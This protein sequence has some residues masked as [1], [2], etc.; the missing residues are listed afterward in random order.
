MASHQPV[1]RFV[2]HLQAEWYG[3]KG[4]GRGQGLRRTVFSPLRRNIPVYSVHNTNVFI[5]C[6]DDHVGKLSSSSTSLGLTEFTRRMAHRQYAQEVTTSLVLEQLLTSIPRKSSGLMYHSLL[7]PDPRS[8]LCIHLLQ[9]SKFLVSFSIR[10]TEWRARCLPHG[11]TAARHKADRRMQLGLAILS[12][13]SGCRLIYVVNRT[14]WT[15]IMRQVAS[16]RSQTPLMLR[17]LVSVLL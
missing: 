13:V 5:I 1:R 7:R 6:Y 3:V 11:A 9:L 2:E 4:E 8:P 10:V 15:I 12:V 14:N 16:P 17:W